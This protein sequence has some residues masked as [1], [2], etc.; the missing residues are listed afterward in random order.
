MEGVH[1]IKNFDTKLLELCIRTTFL[2]FQTSYLDIDKVRE[3]F[4]PTEIC[5]PEKM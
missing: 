2:F 3:I 1:Y 4:K 5:F